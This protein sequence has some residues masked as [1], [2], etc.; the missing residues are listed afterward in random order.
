MTPR[1]AYSSSSIV[2]GLMEKIR[3]YCCYNYCIVL[4]ILKTGRWGWGGVMSHDESRDALFV[5]FVFC[6][7]DIKLFKIIYV[8][9]CI[10]E[11]CRP[12]SSSMRETFQS[13]QSGRVAQRSMLY[14]KKET[15]PTQRTL[16]VAKACTR[17]HRCSGTGGRRNGGSREGERIAVEA[18]LLLLH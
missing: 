9:V 15:G 13:S 17:R 11:L 16:P 14:N 6:H 1:T 8:R 12:C 7:A 5:I 10:L 3:N 4:S 18:L 2:D